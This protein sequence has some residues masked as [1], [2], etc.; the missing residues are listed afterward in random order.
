MAIFILACSH[1]T[2]FSCES[3][4][5]KIEH[6]CVRRLCFLLNV[7]FFCSVKIPTTVKTEFVAVSSCFFLFFFF[8]WGYT[9][10]HF[11]DS[12]SYF[13]IQRFNNPPLLLKMQCSLKNALLCN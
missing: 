12:L 5:V 10:H 4:P 6:R 2:H 9:G 13:F 11:F 3:L 8:F 7:I 1:K